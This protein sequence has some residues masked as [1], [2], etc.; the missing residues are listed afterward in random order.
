MRKGSNANPSHYAAHTVAPIDLIKDYRLNFNLG[1]VIK[2]VARAEE[3]NGREDLIKAAW[4][5]LDELG[6]P[7]EDIKAITS[8]LEAQ[9]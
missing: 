6:M 7:R 2:Y 5:L 9:T 1:N 8:T 4:Y 3:K